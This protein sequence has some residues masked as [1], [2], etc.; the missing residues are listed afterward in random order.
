MKCGICKKDI[1]KTFLDKIEGTYVK[2]RKG[3]KHA[4]CPDCQEK[5]HSKDEILKKL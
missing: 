3:K 1:T 5:Y 2:D 4:V